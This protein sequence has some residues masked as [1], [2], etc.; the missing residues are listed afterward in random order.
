MS[1]MYKNKTCCCRCCC[2][3]IFC[4]YLWYFWTT[5]E[6]Q[7]RYYP[8]L[9]Y[10]KDISKYWHCMTR[11]T[12]ALTRIQ[13]AW[14]KIVAT[15]TI[16]TINLPWTKISNVCML[17][18]SMCVYFLSMYVVFK[19]KITF[20]Y[21]CMQVCVFTFW[22]AI[23][24]TQAYTHTHEC[25]HIFQISE[26]CVWNII[27]SHA[28]HT[29]ILKFTLTHSLTYA[30]SH[31]WTLPRIL[32]KMSFCQKKM[33]RCSHFDCYSCWP[34]GVKVQSETNEVLVGV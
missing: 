24:K 9:C 26:V 21:I 17:F 18:E 5:Q 23:P 25:I 3:C 19:C 13:G 15:T 31:S 22:Y 7:Q 28:Q 12:H 30:H 16:A 8:V 2:C 10:E 14:K 27:Q 6:R 20:Q 33:I 11:P 32:S 1:T 34:F 4:N 29:H